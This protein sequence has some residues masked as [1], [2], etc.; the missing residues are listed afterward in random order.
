MPLSFEE[1]GE[2][3]MLFFSKRLY[4]KKSI[5]PVMNHIPSEDYLAHSAQSEST[6]VSSSICEHLNETTSTQ[7]AGSDPNPVVEHVPMD[8]ADVIQNDALALNIPS[9]QHQLRRWILLLPGKCLR[10]WCLRHW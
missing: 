9:Q 1:R 5:A 10:Q 8:I 6:V 2:W 3:E 4:K 7:F